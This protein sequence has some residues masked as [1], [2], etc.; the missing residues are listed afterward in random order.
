MDMQPD[1]TTQTAPPANSGNGKKWLPGI[2]YIVLGILLVG[3][4]IW[5]A[6]ILMA[7]IPKNPIP[8][9]Q[10]VQGASLVLQSNK[11]TFQEGEIVP[12]Q[13]KLSTGGRSI[14]G[15]D[16][17]LEYDPKM[18]EASPSAFFQKGTIFSDYPSAQVDSTKGIIKISGI[19]S[20][21]AE[22]FTGIGFF[23][24]VNLETKQTGE[25]SVKVQYT[26]G[27]TTDS[28]VVE[29]STAKDV[30]DK[31]YNLDLNIK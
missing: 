2:I 21:S 15:A 11:A 4:I 8:P 6:R 13:I 23:G 18:L 29:S 5:A 30:L 3:A 20:A 24:T 17:V 22:G 9:L 25:T 19:S 14:N 31:V 26:S 1:I 12:V 28:N 10:P 16:V 7:P 27:A